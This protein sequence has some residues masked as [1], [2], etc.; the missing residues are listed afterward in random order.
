MAEEKN[1]EKKA[2]VLTALKGLKVKKSRHF[3]REIL[4]NNDKFVVSKV[5]HKPVKGEKISD[6]RRKDRKY[7][8]SQ[9]FF[10][11]RPL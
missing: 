6:T 2:E 9:R 8:P 5:T 4:E 1:E 7:D 3:R 11:G 10:A